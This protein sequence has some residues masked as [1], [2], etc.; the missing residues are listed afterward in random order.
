MRLNNDSEELT[1]FL[2][3]FGRYCFT[4]LAF[5]I[6]CA[7]EEFQKRMSEILRGYPGINVM[8][9][10]LVFGETIAQHDERAAK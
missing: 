8:D 10:V 2:T 7:P 6:T 4:R 9:D 3:P 5:G 1:T